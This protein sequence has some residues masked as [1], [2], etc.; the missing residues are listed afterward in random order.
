MINDVPLSADRTFISFRSMCVGTHP[1]SA[2]HPGHVAEARFMVTRQK[3]K[4]DSNG[5]ELTPLE[6]LATLSVTV[7]YDDDMNKLRSVAE[8]RLADKLRNLADQ[9]HRVPASVD[10]EAE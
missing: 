5:E 4:K 1:Y 7:E 2:G 10:Q 3:I 8:K 6:G 9:L